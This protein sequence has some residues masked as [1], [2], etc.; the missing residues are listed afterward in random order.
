MKGWPVVGCIIIIL[1]FLS[2]ISVDSIIIR[3]RG[4]T[5]RE[6]EYANFSCEVPCSS[7]VFWFIG[8]LF[9][10]AP[11]QYIDSPGGVMY[12]RIRDPETGCLSSGNRFE[13][14]SILA[15]PD[16]DNMAVQCSVIDASSCESTLY[17]RFRLMKGNFTCSI[18]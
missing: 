2:L 15:M 16:L 18:L 10:S 9:N 12:T 14:L 5:I 3:P 7:D 1:S 13:N 4:I 11:I 6:G 17:S 8:D